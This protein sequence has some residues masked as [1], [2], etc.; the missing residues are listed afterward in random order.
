MGAAVKRAHA[1]D[2]H[3]CEKSQN[4]VDE[5]AALADQHDG[6]RNEWEKRG[7]R[8]LQLEAAL[9]RGGCKVPPSDEL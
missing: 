1:T 4:L 6:L 3:Y 2:D 8:I 7:A 5:L 9:R